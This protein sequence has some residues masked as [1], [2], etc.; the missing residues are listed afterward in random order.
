MTPLKTCATKLYS[1]ATAQIY[2][3]VDNCVFRE[4][5]L[6]FCGVQGERTWSESVSP[7]L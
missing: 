3:D 4:W 1:M 5:L 2:F 7:A 6:L